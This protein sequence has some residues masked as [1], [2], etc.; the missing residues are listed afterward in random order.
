MGGEQWADKDGQ[1]GMG[2]ERGVCGSPS[3]S[4]RAAGACGLIPVGRTVRATARR[5]R[6]GPR[7][8]LGRARARSRR[9]RRRRAPGRRPFA[10]RTGLESS[11]SAQVQVAARVQASGGGGCGG[12]CQCAS[13][14]AARVDDDMVA[15]VWPQDDQAE[16]ELVQRRLQR[17]EAGGLAWTTRVEPLG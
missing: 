17:V 10:R 12:R 4:R 7:T 15:R 14:H 3:R 16:A 13:V 8:Q 2:G 1:T 9:Q 5:R 11:G 6:R